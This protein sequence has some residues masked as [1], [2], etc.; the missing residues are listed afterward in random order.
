M[1][2]QLEPNLWE[3]QLD[4]LVDFGHGVGP[5]LE[6]RVL[7]SLLH[8]ECVAIDMALCSVV[9]KNRGF[10]CD[11]RCERILR[12]LR[13]FELPLMHDRCDGELIAQAL[14]GV[15]RHRGGLQRIPLPH[16][17]GAA[18][19][20]NDLRTEDFIAARRELLVSA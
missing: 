17:I 16:A 13:R 20:H 11:E 9:A 2:Q 15:R 7:P 6:M 18:E 19:I 14:D 1:L 12:L 8:G 3:R 5:A 10:L 4:R